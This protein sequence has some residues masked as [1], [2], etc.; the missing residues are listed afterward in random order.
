MKKISGPTKFEKRTFPTIWFGFLTIVVVI[1]MFGES[2]KLEVLFPIIMMVAG[3]LLFKYIA[4]DLCDEVFDHGDYLL[5][6]KG[7]NEQKVWLKDIMNISYAHL[8]SPERIVIYT[9]SSGTIGNE[10]AFRLPN[11]LNF[12]AKSPIVR[13]L[14]ERVD[15]AR[16]T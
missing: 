1:I 15:N 2:S 14:V 9:K 6:R 11:R 7:D 4:W 16:N 12:F 3:Y 13:E 8:S 10:L 5:F